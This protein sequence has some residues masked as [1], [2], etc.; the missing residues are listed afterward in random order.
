VDV[1]RWMK[2]ACVVTAVLGWIGYLLFL[3]RWIYSLVKERDR[4]LD[5]LG[6]WLRV[7]EAPLVVILLSAIGYS[8]CCLAERFRLPRIRSAL[9]ADYEDHPRRA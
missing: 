6:L 9:E 5:D 7:A 1:L 8:L 4:W 2:G 3:A